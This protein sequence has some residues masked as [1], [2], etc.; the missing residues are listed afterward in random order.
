MGKKYVA[1]TLDPISEDQEDQV[2]DYIPKK[3]ISLDEMQDHTFN[4][5]HMQNSFSSSDSIPSEAYQTESIINYDN[6]INQLEPLDY[7]IIAPMHSAQE[8]LAYDSINLS[9][10]HSYQSSESSIEDLNEN[11]HTKTVDFGENMLENYF[12]EEYCM[13]YIVKKSPKKKQDPET[14]SMTMKE[15]KKIEGMELEEQMKM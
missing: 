15:I 1:S 9:K 11:I 12:T 10:I 4:V 3:K 6:L 13:K 14:A 2:E 7:N 5:E 8:S